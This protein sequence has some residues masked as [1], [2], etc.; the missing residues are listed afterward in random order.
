[1]FQPDSSGT[2]IHVLMLLHIRINGR[3]NLNYLIQNRATLL[4]YDF[5]DFHRGDG[6]SYSTARV[7]DASQDLYS[8]ARTMLEGPI[9]TPPVTNLL[10]GISNDYIHFFSE[11]F[12]VEPIMFTLH[13][14]DCQFAV[15]SIYFC[16]TNYLT[17]D[18][19]QG[20]SEGG[21]P[22]SP[23]S[24]AVTVGGRD[25]ARLAWTK[26]CFAARYGPG[27][28]SCR[29]PASNWA[30][31]GPEPHIIDLFDDIDDAVSEAND[32]VQF[33]PFTPFVSC[34]RTALIRKKGLYRRHY[35][36]RQ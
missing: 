8:V 34:S 15:L 10:K 29:T 27:A 2:Y 16:L 17:N 35:R 13:A 12:D 31:W 7:E 36:G 20:G 26:G 23:D 6:V 5:I 19:E 25:T 28:H 30:A 21:P 18:G 32:M 22:A 33:T 3:Q 4:P 9:L 1:M 24:D 14:S 11:Y